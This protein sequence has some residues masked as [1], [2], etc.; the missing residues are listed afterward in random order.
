MYNKHLLLGSVVI[1]FIIL[2]VHFPISNEQVSKTIYKK[3]ISSEKAVELFDAKYEDAQI[4]TITVSENGGE[5]LWVINY[6]MPSLINKDMPIQGTACVNAV[7]GV[8][9]P[10]TT[11]AN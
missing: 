6:N 9:E 11:T 3:T 5:K 7:T 8:M 2:I 1:I 4:S 10:A